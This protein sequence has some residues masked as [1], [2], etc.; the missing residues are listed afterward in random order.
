MPKPA[1]VVEEKQKQ[2]LNA[3]CTKKKNN[4]TTPIEWK[5]SPTNYTTST[6]NAACK[7][8]YRPQIRRTHS[9]RR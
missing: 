6:N 2:I 5:N 7:H 3:A 9:W 1:I 8:E 4:S